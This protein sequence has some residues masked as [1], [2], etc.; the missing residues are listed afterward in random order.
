MGRIRSIKPEF[1][2]SSKLYQYEVASKLPLRIAFAGLWTACDRDGKFKW[3]EDEL[4]LDCL[5]YDKVDFSRVLDALAT[6]GYV[7]DYIIDGNKYGFIPTWHTHQVINNRESASKLPDPTPESIVTRE[8]RVGDALLKYL[9]GKEGKGKEGEILKEGETAF[10]P[11]LSLLDDVWKFQLQRWI[12]FRSEIKKPFKTQSQIDT[13]IK[14]LIEISG[15]DNRNAE[16]I[17]DYSIAGGYQGLFPSKQ[18]QAQ[19][20]GKPKPA[21]GQEIAE[22]MYKHF[23]NGE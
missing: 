23:G 14:K 4:K 13:Q 16:Q 12:D 17:I 21:T 11:N 9:S 3:I 20:N 1:F 5:P 15:G 6:C 19:Q 18:T 10:I 22:I 8:S 2:R 7:V